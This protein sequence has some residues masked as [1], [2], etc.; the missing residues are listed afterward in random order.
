LTATEA[1]EAATLPAKTTDIPSETE[2]MTANIFF[3]LCP[4]LSVEI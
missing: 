3:I 2:K 1:A 4:Q